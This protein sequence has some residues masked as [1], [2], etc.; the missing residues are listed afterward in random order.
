MNLSCILSNYKLM[1]KGSQHGREE[2]HNQNLVL[3]VHWLN[4][5]GLDLH[6]FLT[7]F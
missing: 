6:C 1:L 4:S 2:V 5:A 7:H 3:T